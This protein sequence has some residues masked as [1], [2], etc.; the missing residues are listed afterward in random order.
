M[1]VDLS[2]VVALED[3]APSVE[4]HASLGS[5]G[6]RILSG[7]L[8]GPGTALRCQFNELR[9]EVTERFDGGVHYRVLVT[10]RGDV[11][12][13]PWVTLTSLAEQAVEDQVY[14]VLAGA[15]FH[16]EWWASY[17]KLNGQHAAGVAYEH[18]AVARWERAWWGRVAVI[19]LAMHDGRVTAELMAPDDELVCTCP[20]TRRGEY[21]P[22]RVPALLAL[23]RADSDELLGWLTRDGRICPTGRPYPKDLPYA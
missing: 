20:S 2:P 23:R 15:D 12:Y 3:G 18:L 17:H 8:V 21:G 13:G 22:D 14:K 1:I 10:R 16:D 11:Q 5:K 9:V 6:E 4:L 19:A 7:R